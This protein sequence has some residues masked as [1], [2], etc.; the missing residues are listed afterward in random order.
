MFALW[1]CSDNNSG[2]TTPVE[3]QGRWVEVGY[4]TDT[5]TF[6]SSANS[7][8]VT[9]ARAKEIKNGHVLPK[10]GS[11]PYEYKVA[12]SKIFLYWTLS[13][14]STFNEY[15]FIR[16]GNRLTVGNFYDPNLGATLVFEK[17]D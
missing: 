6:R 16:A 9:L 3:L 7:D 10:S 13:S 2:L 14:S 15:D 4:R 12:G 5:L 11:G 1:S 17:L 8:V